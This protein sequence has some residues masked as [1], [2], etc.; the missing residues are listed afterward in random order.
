MNEIE[1]GKAKKLHV[2]WE[3]GPK[4][5]IRFG[6]APGKDRSFL[7]LGAKYPVCALRRE[8]K[9]RSIPT[10]TPNKREGTYVKLVMRD[11]LVTEAVATNE[12]RH[13]GL[14]QESEHTTARGGEIANET[15]LGKVRLVAW[16]DEEIGQA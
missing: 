10:R 5:R 4:F 14:R 6:V 9:M 13:G 11:G 7:A 3:R 8:S 16:S 1:A 2:A 12:E 15:S